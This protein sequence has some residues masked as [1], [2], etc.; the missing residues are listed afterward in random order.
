[1]NARK[2]VVFSYGWRI[3]SY[4]LMFMCRQVLIDL[5][6]EMVHNMLY[7]AMSAVA[8]RFDAPSLVACR[9]PP[10]PSALGVVLLDTT[11]D[12][13]VIEPLSVLLRVCLRLAEAGRIDNC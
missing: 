5:I 1:M 10:Y 12:Q 13:T 4:Q 11:R 8:L 7:A 6:L 2:S 9:V 3:G